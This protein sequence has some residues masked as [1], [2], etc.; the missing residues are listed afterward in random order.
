MCESVVFS[1]DGFTTC[2]YNDSG[3]MNC[4]RIARPVVFRDVENASD[5]GTFGFLKENL[6][7]ETSEILPLYGSSFRETPSSLRAM[8]GL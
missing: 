5:M 1:N 7:S 6:L 8:E 2:L 3:R 4:G